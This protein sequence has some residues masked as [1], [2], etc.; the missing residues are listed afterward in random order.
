MWMAIARTGAWINAFNLLPVW[1]LDG[2]RGLVAL[3]KPDRF[4]VAAAFVAG[5]AICGDGL[6]VLLALTA[7]G[8]AA[9]EES[10]DTSD[11][12][13]LALFVFLIVALALVF[14][15][16]SGSAAPVVK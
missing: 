13:V 16:A 11:R 12:R 10:T 2:S 5:W 3:S 15:V 14:R 4:V 6:F 1:Q 7:A 8:R 9:F